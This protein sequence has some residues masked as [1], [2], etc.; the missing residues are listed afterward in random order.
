MAT[1][2]FVIKDPSANKPSPVLML[3][4]FANKRLKY[5]TGE[6]ID[7]KYW[8]DKKNRASET[9]KFPQFP[10]FNARLQNIE[11]TA[12]N[13]YRKLLNDGEAV[14]LESMKEGLDRELKNISSSSI[15]LVEDYILKFMDDSE[16][17]KR[18]TKN[19]KR[20]AKTTITAYRNCLWRFQE[21]QKDRG[22]KFRF[23]DITL[24]FYDDWVSWL[25]N[26]GYAKN[27][28]AKHIKNLKVF[29]R[30][31][32]RQGLHDNRAFEDKAFRKSEE[33]TDKVYLTEEE[34]KLLFDL[35]LSQ[36]KRLD[37]VRDLFLVGCYT[38][39]RFSDY[40]QVTEE[41]FVNGGSMLK[42]RA[43]KTNEPVV[44]PLHW[45]VKDILAKH[46]NQ[47]PKIPSNVK[48]NLYLK[49]LCQLAGIDSNVIVSMTKAGLRVDS[50]QPKYELV[51]TH[52]A[53]RSFI[54]NMIKSGIP[55]HM[56]MKITHKSEQ[57]FL[58][59]IRT[60]N[61][62]NASLLLDMSFFQKTRSLMLLR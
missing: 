27:T 41:N 12:F 19:G 29:M 1:S 24:N 8:N 43:L 13:I 17:G 15:E 10:E 5:S 45:I 58:R 22:K 42:A 54:T 30:N 62:E 18:L 38:G 23:E 50:K 52:T 35:D 26:Q 28:V 44:I 16:K 11:D 37:K 61:E 39:L 59:Y 53:R 46:Q 57:A 36:N 6:K 60:D 47:L 25:T 51:T 55:W 31:A 48:M 34:L 14:T 49:E 2:T 4:R 21:Y 56:V 9:R 40:N 3:F 20:I 33:I 7:P 32:L